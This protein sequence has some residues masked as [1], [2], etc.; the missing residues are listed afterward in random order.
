M[1]KQIVH[2]ILIAEDCTF[3]ILFIKMQLDSAKKKWLLKNFELTIVKSVDDLIKAM[4]EKTFS[5]IFLDHNLE[6]WGKIEIET[7][8]NILADWKIHINNILSTTW[9][10]DFKEKLIE[11]WIEHLEKNKIIPYIIN[12]FI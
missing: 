6:F 4:K 2:K 12:R 3:E 7:I 1:N 10:D 9:C 8:E 11:K 5:L